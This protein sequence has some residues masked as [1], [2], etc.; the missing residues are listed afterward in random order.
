MKT[1]CSLETARVL[2]R[3]LRVSLCAIGLVMLP[4]CGMDIVA[5]GTD[6]PPADRIPGQ[7]LPQDP[8]PNEPEAMQVDFVDNHLYAQHADEWA[9]L[10][11]EQPLDP[12]VQQIPPDIERTAL[13]DPDRGLPELVAYLV[14]DAPSE[15]VRA[16]LIHDW[17]A[18]RIAYDAEAFLQG[19]IGSQAPEDVLRQ[20]LAVCDGYAALF[21]RMATLA[22]LR[23][24]TVDGVV[25]AY[26][27]ARTGQPGRHAWNAVAADGRVYLLDVTADA[28][29][30]TDGAFKKQYRTTYLFLAPTA[31]IYSHLPSRPALQLLN[32][33]ID[34][35]QFLLLPLL[36]AAFFNR[37]LPLPTALTDTPAQDTLELELA[38]PNTLLRAVLLPQDEEQHERHAFAQK[39]DDVCSLRVA[40]WAAGDQQLAVYARDAQQSGGQQYELVITFPVHF[41]NSNALNAPFPFFSEAFIEQA[42]SLASPRQGDLA[43]QSEQ[44]FDLD[45]PG[46]SEVVLA[47]T[48]DR[49]WT[50]LLPSGANGHVELTYRVPAEAE[51]V[52]LQARFGHGGPWVCLLEYTVR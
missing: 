39:R 50:P 46:A 18:D 22:G 9:Q 45:I 38:C 14:A 43:P 31:M 41:G 19:R 6:T 42:A 20:G 4:A 3:V 13:E 36:S 34:E 28:G 23:S 51:S 29:T 35:A 12:R 26:T 27:F 21:T 30:L 8:V 10:L 7:E 1:N 17:I 52:I 44:T 24:L 37:T 49:S 32:A 2:A 47:T 11:R 15:L 25:K 40:A 16:K 33:P 48:P 5:G